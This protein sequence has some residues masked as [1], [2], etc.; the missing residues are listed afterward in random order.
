M[1]GD[2]VRVTNMHY[3]ALLR[4]V[5]LRCVPCRNVSRHSSVETEA[6]CIQLPITVHRLVGE[7]WLP[8]SVRHCVRQTRIAFSRRQASLRGAGLRLTVLA[9]RGVSDL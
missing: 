1:Q 7:L 4:S 2:E 8:P 5:P 3:T 6:P 9:H